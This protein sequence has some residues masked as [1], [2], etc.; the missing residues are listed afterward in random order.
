ML[1]ALALK[2]CMATELIYLH[3]PPAA[4]KFT[5]AKEISS[6]LGSKLLHNHLTIDVAKSVFEFG[7][8]VFWDL[9]DNLRLQTIEAA[10]KN[11]VPSV[12]ITSCYDHPI[13]LP[14]Y[15]KIEYIADVHNGVVRP[16]FLSCS[17]NE[18]ETRVSNP[19]RVEMGKLVTVSGLRENLREWNCIPV[20]RDSCI[21]IDTE[22]R[23]PANC[24]ESIREELQRG[25]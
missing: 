21:T 7:S 8:E 22:N 15:E 9:A 14:F 18:L 13:D 3:G 12:I 4:G 6:I 19:T 11:R 25:S 17:T 23:T 20:P 1:L 5:I 2:V 16:F 24:A 10:F